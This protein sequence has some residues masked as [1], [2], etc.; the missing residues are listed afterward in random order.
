MSSGTEAATMSK[1]FG[2]ARQ[3]V[4]Q[5]LRE[6]GMDNVADLLQTTTAAKIANEDFISGLRASFPEAESLLIAIHE[7]AKQYQKKGIESYNPYEFFEDMPNGGKK[8]QPRWL[9]EDIMDDYEFV[10]VRE[11]EKLYVYKNDYWKPQGIRIVEEECNKRL[12]DEHRATRAREVKE[13]IKTETSISRYDFT[14]PNYKINFQNGVYNLE[15]SELEEHDKEDYFTQKIPWSYDPNAVNPAIN[16]FLDQITHTDED[17]ESLIEAAGYCMLPNIPISKAFILVGEGSNGKTQFLNILKEMIGKENYKEEDL[18]QLE[19]TRFGTQSL[20]QKLALFSDDL[21]SKALQSANTFKSLVGGGEVRAEYKGGAHFQFENYATPVFAC[22]DIPHSQDDSDG[23]YR[24]WMIVNF[25]YKFKNN[26]AESNPYEKEKKP[27]NELERE[28]L[29]EDEIKGFINDAIVHLELV[30][31]QGQFTHDMDVEEL[32]KLWNAYSDPVN[33]FIEKYVEQGLTKNEAENKAQGNSTLTSFDFDYIVKDD[34]HKLIVDYCEARNTRPPTKQKLTKRL[35][36]KTFFFSATRSVVPSDDN[37][38]VQ[39]YRGLKFSDDFWGELKSL[40]GLQGYRS[41]PRVR[42]CENYIDEV[43]SRYATPA[44]FS[45][46][47]DD[48]GK[49]LIAKVESEFSDLKEKQGDSVDYQD[50][51]DL[52]EAKHDLSE[53][54]VIE[55]I[56]HKKHEGMWYSPKPGRVDEI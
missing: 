43:S 13:I 20:Y 50:L 2:N 10:W 19:D 55:V 12:E 9:A 31:N 51:I 36:G 53:D 24:R 14:P 17:K 39:I 4:V 46:N 35:Q 28:I 3:T 44:S 27:E 45:E 33:E 49:D 32:R 16:D 8:F 40:Q 26:P 21:P 42:V 6:K 5:K 7:K 52:C 25:P 15:T 37:E 54:D 1:Q 23:F 22:N 41:I 56:D 11:L 18:Q 47:S 34:L 29:D 38:Q 30:L 48:S